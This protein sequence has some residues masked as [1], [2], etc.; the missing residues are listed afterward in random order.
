M[1]ETMIDVLMFLFDN[2]LSVDEGFPDDEETLAEA[3]EDAGFRSNTI[4]QAFD[5]LGELAEIQMPDFTSTNY[6]AKAQRVF[7]Q[8]ELRKLDSSCRGFLL[9]LE[10]MGVVDPVT[11]EVIIE[12]AMALESEELTLTQF[13]RIAGLVMLNTTENEAMLAFIEDL[14]FD[15]Y[16]VTMH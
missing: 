16:S 5:W 13:K 1:K 9:S 4:N 7:A 14:L 11:R 12:R 15:E 3:L 8:H 10:K 6:S 2:F